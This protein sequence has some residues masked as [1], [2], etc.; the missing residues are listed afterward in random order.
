MTDM[1]VKLYD[2]PDSAPAIADLAQKGISVR[3]AT[4]AD[5]AELA[6]WVAQD[7]P[8]WAKEASQAFDA[9]AP[10]CFVAAGNDGLVGFACYDVTAPNFFGPMAVHDDYREKGVGRAL[11]LAALQAQKEQGYGYAIIGGV[12]PAGFY[13]RC[14]GATLI[15]GS[16]SGIYG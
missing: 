16:T 4:P 12:G 8:A 11:L 15:D 3:R 14:V 5:Q 2:L 7:F 10:T 9:P 13:E 6:A 1:L